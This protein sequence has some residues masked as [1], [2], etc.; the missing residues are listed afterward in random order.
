[1]WFFNMNTW[2]M[3]SCNVA[4]SRGFQLAQRWFTRFF[5]DAFSDFY[6]PFLFP[7]RPRFEIISK[8]GPGVIS[9]VQKNNAGRIDYDES[10]PEDTRISSS[11]KALLK[12]ALQELL[13]TNA[14]KFEHMISFDQFY[15]RA[16]DVVHRK[17][18]NLA[19][20][21]KNRNYVFNKG[22]L[23][24]GRHEYWKIF[25]HW[26]FFHMMAF[27]TLL[28]DFL[29]SLTTLVLWP[30]A[31]ISFCPVQ[32]IFDFATRAKNL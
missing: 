13:E 17:V 9:G 19:Y 24:S 16:D 12:P 26:A 14:E 7:Y 5:H 18:T 22:A 31:S 29:N 6:W 2:Y 8:K 28:L 30:S 1:M 21:A 11:L 4:S 25:F 23:G 20:L 15:S 10:L 32:D 3:V 27:F